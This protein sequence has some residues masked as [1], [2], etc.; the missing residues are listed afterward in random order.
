MPSL[1]AI[2]AACASPIENGRRRIVIA[3]LAL[4]LKGSIPGWPS[5]A[6]SR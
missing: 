6:L 3:A 1:A 4:P 2:S 5:A